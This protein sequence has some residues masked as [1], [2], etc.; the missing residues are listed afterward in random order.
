MTT[1]KDCAMSKRKLWKLIDNDAQDVREFSSHD[2]LREYTRMWG[3]EVHKSTTGYRTYY[4]RAI[5]S[6]PKATEGIVR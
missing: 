5:V 3:L 6:L 4:S 2:N 1:R